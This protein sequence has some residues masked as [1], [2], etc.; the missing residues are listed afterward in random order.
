MGKE[1]VCNIRYEGR[2]SHG[3]ALLE[4]NELLFRGDFRLKIPLKQIQSAKAKHGELH[5]QSTEGSAVFELGPQAAKWV[6]KILHPPSLLDKLGVKTGLR[7]ALVGRFDDSFRRELKIGPIKNADLIFL[8]A[9][10]REAL[11]RLPDL[12][13]SLK[14]GGAI[15]VV[16]PK[17]Q[18]HITEAHVLA[19][20]RASGLVDVKVAGFSA[21]H[22]ALKF[23][24]RRAC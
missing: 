4:S 1:A 6:E 23:V 17:G 20:G 13:T 22:T 2:T 3:K 15:W 10:A 24:I 21:T 14:S 9:E 16:Y 18:K 8:A 5:I 19:A 11:D 12:H 7:A